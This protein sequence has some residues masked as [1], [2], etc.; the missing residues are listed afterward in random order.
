MFGVIID[1]IN[2]NDL[3]TCS[4]GESLTEKKEQCFEW[5]EWMIDGDPFCDEH[6]RAVVKRLKEFDKENTPRLYVREE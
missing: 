5:A 3:F 4:H 1:K 2:K 6:K